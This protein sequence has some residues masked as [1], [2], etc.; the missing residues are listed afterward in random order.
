M[1]DNWYQMTGDDAAAK[2][3]TSKT[4][5]LSR[6][7]V[8]VSQRKHGKNEIYPVSKITFYNCLKAIT[9][10]YTSYL[11]I[12]T[13]LIA[14]I[15]E[16][17]VGAWTLVVLVALNLIATVLAYAK[18]QRILEGMDR[19]TL[20]VVRVI[21]EGRLFMVD[22]K[23]LVPG[24]L[25]C[26]SRGD[27]VP[28]D[29]RLISAHD[30][31]VDEERLFG[32]TGGASMHFK[33]AEVA[34]HETLPPEKQR[35]M[36][37]AGT[38]VTSGE[39]TAL[40]C[41]TGDATVISITEKNHPII[42]HESMPL[43]GRLQKISRVWSLIVIAAV[44]AMTMLDFLMPGL[45]NT[46]FASFVGAMS[47]AVST[48]SEMYVA[49]GYIVLACAVWQTVQLFRESGGAGAILKN[50]LCMDNL[51]HITCL[52]VPKEGIFTTR[53]TVADRIFAE[54][55]L[56]DIADRR[57]R[58]AMERPILYAILS[59][60]MY[61]EQ[62]LKKQ[63]AIHGSR[64]TQTEE[65]ASI[66]NLARQMDIYNV[67]LDRAYPLLDH[68]GVGGESEFETSLV[69][70]KENY[71]A[72]SR[73][74]CEQILSR[75]AYYYR[76]GRIMLLSDEIRSK[77]LIAYRKLVRQAYS[78]VAV[79][80]H[81]SQYNN[82][83][84]LGAVQR[85][86]V[87]EGFV[88][89][90]V[91][92][93][94]GI[95]QLVGDAKEAGIKII[96]TSERPAASEAY[97]ARQVGIIDKKDQAVDGAS[98][99][100][101]KE[102]IR[103]TNASYFRLYCGLDTGQKL[104][105]VEY[106]RGEGE[107]V[108]VVGRRLEDLCLLRAAD[109]SFA[110]NIAVQ[111]GGPGRRDTVVSKVSESAA[112]EGCEALKF[113]S[114][115]IISDADTK[116]QGGFR[117]ILDALGIAKN[118]D[119]NVVRIMKYLLCAQTAR[120]LLVLYT[121]L[122][123]KEGM[124]AVQ[125]LFSGLFMD[126]MAVFIIAFQKPAPDVLRSASDA[127][128][129]LCH[130]IKNNIPSIL[131]GV[132]WACTA[133]TASFVAGLVGFANS[134]LSV[135]SILFV[136]SCLIGVLMLFSVQREDFVWRPGVRMSALHAIYLLAIVELFL[137]F[138]LFPTFGTVFGVASFSPAV[139]IVIVVMSLIQ[140]VLAECIK[141][142]AR[143]R[144]RPDLAAQD[145]KNEEKHME[146][147]A[148][149]HLFRDR[150]EEENRMEAAADVEV[151]SGNDPAKAGKHPKQKKSSGGLFGRKKPKTQATAESSAPDAGVTDAAS[152]ETAGLAGTVNSA[153]SAGHADSAPAGSAASD[154]E[155]LAEMEEY[156]ARMRGKAK[157]EK[158]AKKAARA[159]LAEK[160]PK[161][162]EL[163]Q[164]ND[165]FTEDDADSMEG[166]QALHTADALSEALS[167][168]AAERKRTV[169]AVD[170]TGIFD[171][172]AMDE[173][174]DGSVGMPADGTPDPYA[175][176]AAMAD[177][178]EEPA[179]RDITIG[180]SSM[181]A[182]EAGVRSFLRTPESVSEEAETARDADR[183]FLGIGYLFS[184][185]EYEAIMAEYNE[186]GTQNAVYNT[187]TRDFDAV[188]DADDRSV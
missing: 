131:T 117:A 107:V 85:D 171:I 11:L 66:L 137:L 21:R 8:R 81:A 125:A 37:F 121:I 180:G 24:D 132:T 151:P 167:D 88:A 187:E 185:E 175:F 119:M 26:L 141:M 104:E 76:N 65:E 124:S 103:R 163:P 67:R 18:S 144:E 113:E 156:V 97:F 14:A 130:P 2:L 17:T 136:T 54:E 89:F 55:T 48:M 53:D 47:F 178:A 179:T 188:S 31:C 109:V 186:D 165:W 135:G 36:V 158:Q 126:F 79:A 91:P 1:T 64:L 27:I 39:A 68:R 87:F 106:L 80:S 73:G 59:T 145:E 164:K 38:L 12:A 5:G 114:D 22:Q 115:I 75:C 150:L 94:R 9:L 166:M 71:I 100:R 176:A 58:R 154:G 111:S 143:M 108:G 155:T 60:G 70:H 182:T 63:S 77:I 4:E 128:P 82:L 147:A 184:E 83:K 133:I 30:F 93:L 78:I 25:I 16:E 129:W 118:T 174:A 170:A 146:I 140:L 7:A 29:A 110:Q 172:P 49:F 33:T 169:G 153:D 40:I 72:I 177:E 46:L 86:M 74:E 35:N 10:D 6:K 90:R 23:Q 105:L 61:G 19:Y 120:F 57:G 160:A 96:L 13:A 20:P 142:L 34:L 116:G 84:F 181:A 69:A 42:S 152:P 162:A 44:F 138:F 102:G 161:K 183:E 43:L 56:Y 149:F 62:Y 173:F 99:R 98:L 127:E 41:A 28:A 50:P 168:F 101:M 95:G 112:E 134:A 32:K 123:S 148:L 45:N 52:V 159:R 51:R 122:F 15:F 92:Y 3:K 139:L 157:K